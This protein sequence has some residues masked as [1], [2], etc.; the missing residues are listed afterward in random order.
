MIKY[1]KDGLQKKAL[2]AVGSLFLCSTSVGNFIGGA[3]IHQV[4]GMQTGESYEN[5]QQFHSVS[6]KCSVAFPEAPEHMKQLLPIADQESQLQYD[7]YVSAM[8][9]QAVF[10]VLIA[11]YPSYVD[12]EYAELSLESFLNGIL[13][14]N[15]NN[16][17]VFADL[18]NVQGYK[19]LDFFIQT[20]GSYFKGRAVIAKNNLY[21][22]AMECEVKNYKEER[23]NHFI[24]SFEI[25]K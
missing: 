6:G 1:I 8:E 21:L 14:Q 23:Y 15:P 4:A 7:V 11:E 16:R 10:M 12:Q 13:T 9:K 19:A 24:N 22:L 20:K 18:V 25:S 17:L 3:S 5:W 2:A